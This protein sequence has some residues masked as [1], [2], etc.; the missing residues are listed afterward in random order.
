MMMARRLAG[1]DCASACDQAEEEAG[2]LSR[3]NCFDP[4]TDPKMDLDT[5]FAVF[6]CFASVRFARRMGGGRWWWTTRAAR[7]H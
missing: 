4:E 6:P 7:S 5:M 1:G 2:L 3:A